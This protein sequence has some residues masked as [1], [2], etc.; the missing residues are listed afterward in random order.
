MLDGL[1]RESLAGLAEAATGGSLIYR[2]LTGH[3]SMYAAL[4]VSTANHP[5]QTSVPAETGVRVDEAVTINRRPEELFRF[6]RD[7]RNLPRFL[8]HLQSVEVMGAT[9]SRWTAR[10]LGM[11]VSWEAEVI[12]EREPSLIAWRSLEGSEVDTAGSVHFTPAPGG[13]GTEVRVE[14]KYQPPA[15]K[16]GATLAWL[17]GDSAEIQI[18]EDLHRLKQMMEAGEVPTAQ[19]QFAGRA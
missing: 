14:L 10:A 2:G 19:G 1:R 3:C 17:F 9:R 18:R 12:N 11:N 16:L 6:W 5:S 4:G 7:F 15:G 13:H 8:T